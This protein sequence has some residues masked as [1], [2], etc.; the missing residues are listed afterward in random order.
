MFLIVF[1][2]TPEK[3][4]WTFTSSGEF[5]PNRTSGAVIMLGPTEHYQLFKLVD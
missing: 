4:G 3:K 2:S 1:H 5:R